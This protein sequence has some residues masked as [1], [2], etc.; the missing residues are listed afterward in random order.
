LY[1]IPGSGLPHETEDTLLL[2]MALNH[3][4]EADA[5]GELKGD[6]TE[7]AVIEYLQQTKGSGWL[8]RVVNLMP[9]VA[10]IPFDSSRKR[11]TTC[12]AYGNINLAWVKGGLE[13]MLQIRSADT[14]AAVV[15]GLESTA[16]QW[17]SDGKRVLAYGYRLLPPDVPVNSEIEQDIQLAGLVAM[18]DPPREESAIAIRE[19]KNAGIQPVMITGD[20]P[21]TATAIARQIGMMEP[22]EKAVSGTEL[23]RMKPSELMAE[24]EQIRVYARVSPE[25]KLQIVEALQH[26]GH[27]VAMTGDGVN[28]APSLKRSN[29]G[30]A[31]GITGTDVCKEA[32]HMVLLDDNFATIVKAIKEGR[33]IYDNIRKFIKYILTCNGAE[34]WTIFLAPLL[35]LPIP[36]LPIH[37]LWINLVTDGLPGLALAG[38]KAEANVMQRPPR[39]AGESLFA[40]GIGLHI[41]WVGMLMAAITLGTHAYTLHQGIQHGQTIVFTVLAFAQLGHLLAI[42]SES[43]FLYQQGLFTNKGLLAALLLTIVLQLLVIYTPA[44]NAFF[45]TQPLTLTELGICL[46]ISAVV[47]HAVE[48]EKFI[49]VRRNLV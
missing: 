22:W 36:L 30:V 45:K 44:G 23:A 29:I 5:S 14:P 41:V 26:K 46:G 11:M 13:A 17:A 42:R 9:R 37:L 49:R 21:L 24:I 38:E 20:H 16:S 4:V 35:G 25:Q 15:A 34:V 27:Y 33:R 7:I 3:N 6:P 40:K 43:E 48:L 8:S 19:C 39:P 2:A 28:D 18:I 12:H 32:A 1:T 31:M 10:E 47:F